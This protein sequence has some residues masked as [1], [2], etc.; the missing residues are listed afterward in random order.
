MTPPCIRSDVAENDEPAS[1]STL[2]G[3]LERVAGG[4]PSAPRILRTAPGPGGPK[5]LRWDAALDD[6]DGRGARIALLGGGICWERLV[7]AGAAIRVRDFTG[8][9]HLRDATGHGTAHASLLVGR[10]ADGFGG[11][12][13]R[14]ELLFARVLGARD[15]TTAERAVA[16]ALRWAVDMGA[17]VVALPFGTW[18]CAPRVAEAIERAS[19]S[20]TAILAAAGDR[21]PGRVAFPA[22][23][24]G[25]VAVTGTDVR[26]RVLPECCSLEQADLAAPGED[27]RAVGPTG[28]MALRGSAPAAVLAAAVEALRRAAR[29]RGARPRAASADPGW[30]V[31]GIAE[32]PCGARPRT[33]GPQPSSRT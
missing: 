20:G 8:G 2:P 30:T 16:A 21:G 32:A 31:S 26:G 6:E 22:W 28:P 29:S 19:R 18:R 33:R 9:R 27:V 11:L 25:V 5:H 12:A 1:T 17:D 10:P 14:A 24:D 23:L 4:R 7:F 3:A 15:R 13:P